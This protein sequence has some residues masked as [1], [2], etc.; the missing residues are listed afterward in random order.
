MLAGIPPAELRRQ[1]ASL[2]LA[3]HAMDPHRL[4]L[5]TI[6][7]REETQP[8]L[9]SRRPIATSG[10]DLLSASLPNETKAH[11]IARMW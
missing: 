8:R 3:R 2:A 4:V 11:W 10:K 5:H 7:T 1:A 6:T 9:K